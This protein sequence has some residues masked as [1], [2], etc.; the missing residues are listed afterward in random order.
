[1]IK[2]VKN[3]P[4]ILNSYLFAQ[5]VKEP[6]TLLFENMPCGFWITEN[7]GSQVCGPIES[8]VMHILIKINHTQ[9]YSCQIRQEDFVVKLPF[10]AKPSKGTR[11]YPFSTFF[12]PSL[13]SFTTN[14]L[15]AI[16]SF[17][18]KLFLPCW[19]LLGRFFFMNKYYICYDQYFIF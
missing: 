19:L 8:Q 5:V 6:P 4:R 9:L 14:I 7:G 12:S 15:H 3:N 13:L 16:G 11:C 10:A 17:I 18:V 2:M 1:M